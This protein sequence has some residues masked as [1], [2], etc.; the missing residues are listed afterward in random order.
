MSDD[1][2]SKLSEDDYLFGVRCC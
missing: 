2:Q 1:V